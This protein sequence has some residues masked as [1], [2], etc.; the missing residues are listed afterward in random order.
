MQEENSPIENPTNDFT[1]TSSNENDSSY[2]VNNK[3]DEVKAGDKEG[4]VFDWNSSAKFLTVESNEEFEVGETLI[5]DDTGAQGRVKKVVSFV[6]IIAWATLGLITESCPS[7][8][9]W[10]IFGE[11]GLM[12]S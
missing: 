4:I 11:S 3:G 12:T 10:V 7:F 5:A 2:W 6:K 1:N 8:T 9:T